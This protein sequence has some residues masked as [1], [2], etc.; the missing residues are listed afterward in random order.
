MTMVS[1]AQNFEDVML[2]RA[3]KDIENGF[4]ID[5][6]ANDPVID[7]VSLAFYERGWRGVHIEPMPQYAGKLRDARP[8]ERV[9]Q[10][11]IGRQDGSIVF[12]EIEDTGLSTAEAEV[13]EQHRKKGF[14]V[15]ETTVD[16]RPLSAILNQY[17]DR[18]IHWMKI[19]VEGLEKEVI[20]SW[21]DA[22]ARP[23]ILVIESTRPLT[24]E[25]TYLEWEAD[26]LAKGYGF[27]YFDGLN[28]FYIHETHQDLL[29]HF[30]TPPNVF[31]E[32]IL[33]GRASNT[34]SIHVLE[35]VRQAQAR[36]A[37][38]ETKVGQFEARHKEDEAKLNAVEMQLKAAQV[39]ANEAEARI[40]EAQAR[41]NEAESRLKDAEAYAQLLLTSTSWRVTA[42]LR[43]TGDRLRYLKSDTF[44]SQVKV[45]LRHAAA[46]IG[47]RPQLKR[48]ALVILNRF[49]ALK[50]RL[51]RIAADAVHVAALP[52]QNI[53][54]ELAEMTPRAR[55]VFHD[56]KD[57]IGRKNKEN[58]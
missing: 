17:N 32:A 33:S 11:A 14:A 37:D 2:W 24:T 38:A 51:H 54:T 55:L 13:A 49:P 44:K 1:Y 26:I 47:G 16:V 27:A 9:E 19:D 31:D 18:P 39:T 52:A 43:A 40:R 25:E 6:G 41:A 53:P 50:L 5:I 28:R 21:D 35:D 4:Y 20:E 3:L 15:T 57:V 46:Y 8:D 58:R 45:Q 7:S 10:I 48:A 23:W 29:K 36:A 42:P 56:L 30:S 12:F 34:L 22:V